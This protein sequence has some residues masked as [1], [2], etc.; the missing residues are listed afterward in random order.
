MVKINVE[1]EGEDEKK[2]IELKK[3]SGLNWHDFI[4]VSAGVVKQRDLWK[5]KVKED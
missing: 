2:L 3:K 1:F 5:R 4:L